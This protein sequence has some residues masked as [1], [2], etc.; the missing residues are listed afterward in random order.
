MLDE[1]V[2]GLQLGVPEA[3]AVPSKRD[4]MEEE[5]QG[6]SSRLRYTAEANWA[7]SDANAALNGDGTRDADVEAGRSIAVQ[8]DVT[9]T[10]QG[11]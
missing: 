11:R 9:V 4:M 5:R 10:R 8:H 2:D 7:S 6:D 3:V 1:E